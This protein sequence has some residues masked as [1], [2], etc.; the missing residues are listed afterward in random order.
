MIELVKHILLVKGDWI[1]RCSI[2]SAYLVTLSYAVVFA[3]FFSIP[4]G[5]ASQMSANM[6][7]ALFGVGIF[8]AGLIALAIVIWLVGIISCIRSGLL[9]KKSL[10]RC[11]WVLSI[12]LLTLIVFSMIYKGLLKGHGTAIHEYLYHLKVNDI[13]WKQSKE[14]T[15]DQLAIVNKLI[16]EQIDVPYQEPALNLS[17]NKILENGETVEEMLERNRRSYIDMHDY[18]VALQ[19]KSFRKKRA[20]AIKV[21]EMEIGQ[22]LASQQA[23]TQPAEELDVL[24]DQRK[25]WLSKLKE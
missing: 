6:D 8:L 5:P 23:L 21:L 9:A 22:L 17:E 18:L 4:P 13:A 25:E 19:K 7:R 14:P 2:L 1:L 11:L 20:W 12:P 15:P 16:Q 10:V 24:I 3:I